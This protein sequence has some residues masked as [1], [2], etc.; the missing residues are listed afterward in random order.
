MDHHSCLFSIGRYM[1]PLT[2]VLGRMGLQVDMSSRRQRKRLG[3]LSFSTG[4]FIPKTQGTYDIKTKCKQTFFRTYISTPRVSRQDIVN[5]DY[6]NKSDSKT[7]TGK[8]RSVSFY[9]KNLP[10]D[11]RL[12]FRFVRCTTVLIYR[13]QFNKFLWFCLLSP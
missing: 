1:Y 9:T 7:F 4:R 11:V 8:P 5:M 12:T 10:P 13:N 6:I 3:R 2:K